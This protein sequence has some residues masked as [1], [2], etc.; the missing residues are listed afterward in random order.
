MDT[1]EFEKTAADVVDFEWWS[2]AVDYTGDQMS[3]DASHDWGHLLRVIRNAAAIRRA[4]SKADWEVVAA[5]CLMHDIVNVPKDHPQRD[6][7]STK[8]AGV[9]VE[10][11]QGIESFDA[12]KLDKLAD[13]IRTHSYSAGLRPGF[14]ESEILCDADRLDALGA[15]GI[16][17]CFQ[18]SGQ[19]DRAIV[20][21]ADPFAGDRELDDLNYA[22]DHFFEKLLHLEDRFYTEEGR[23]MAAQR[24][25]F[26]RTFL[27][28]LEVELDPTLDQ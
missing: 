5:A 24:T 10:F 22:V 27:E 3:R 11:F 15:F 20:D 28:Q 9:A 25:E 18:V 6:R 19:L 1:A 8:S 7:A 16:A 26:V 12:P 14:L 23:R 2:K 17:R 21:M 13:A 4:E